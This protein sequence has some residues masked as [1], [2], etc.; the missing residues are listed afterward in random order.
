MFVGVVSLIAAVVWFG[1]SLMHG[2]FSSI[3]I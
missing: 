2:A 3:T 1:Y